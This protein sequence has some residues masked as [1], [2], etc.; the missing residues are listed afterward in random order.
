MTRRDSQRRGVCNQKVASSI[1]A[2]GTIKSNSYV[3]LRRPQVSG[4]AIGGAKPTAMPPSST[5]QKRV[6]RL[7][8]ALFRKRAQDCRLESR[9]RQGTDEL[10]AGKRIADR[11]PDYE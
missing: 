8:V 7:S 10:Y 2:A 9:K 3:L 6:S 11:A 1:L 4:G 5:L